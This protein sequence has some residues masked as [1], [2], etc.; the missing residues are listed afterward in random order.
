LSR[1][2]IPELVVALQNGAPLRD[3]LASALQ[4]E[5]LTVVYWL[6]QRQGSSEGGWVDLQGHAATEPAPTAGR[7]VK[8]VEQD[9]RRIAAI[10]YDAALDDEPDLLDAVTAAASLTLRSD[11]LQAELRAEVE[12]L[13]TVTNTVASM[14]GIVGTDGRVHGVKERASAWCSPTTRSCCGRGSLDC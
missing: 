1:V 4:D 3:A 14:L 13:D 10:T 12:F 8:L 6:D 11:R 9:G 5:G 7:A 2:S